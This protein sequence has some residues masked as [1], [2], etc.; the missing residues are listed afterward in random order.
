MNRE[1][2]TTNNVITTLFDNYKNNMVLAVM[3]NEKGEFN[4][5]ISRNTKI[6]DETI[7][8]GD[9]SGIESI[10]KNTI[11]DKLSAIVKTTNNVNRS[12]F[13][14]FSCW[15][16]NLVTY[17]YS[18]DGWVI[19]VLKDKD[20]KKIS[21]LLVEIMNEFSITPTNILIGENT[22]VIRKIMTSITKNEVPNMELKITFET[23]EEKEK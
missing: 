16:K 8:N 3:V 19:I 11:S 5:I 22:K 7:Q 20:T 9:F 12:P 14:V 6:G 23:T 15:D 2:T 18:E 10:L 21:K 13:Y 1:T 4:P 17:F